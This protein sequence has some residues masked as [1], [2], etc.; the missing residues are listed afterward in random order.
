MN[1]FVEVSESFEY[2]DM[3]Y[4]AV[5]R[6]LFLTHVEGRG[7]LLGGTFCLCRFVAS[8][9]LGTASCG[10]SNDAGC[11]R[12]DAST[13]MAVSRPPERR[14]AIR[15]AVPSLV[16][17]VR[18]SKNGAVEFGLAVTRERDTAVLHFVLWVLATGLATAAAGSGTATTAAAAGAEAKKVGSSNAGGESGARRGGSGLGDGIGVVLSAVTGIITCSGPGEGGGPSGSSADKDGGGGRLG[19]GGEG[20]SSDA[21]GGGEA[22]SGG[23]S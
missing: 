3:L 13:S 21:S 23:G 11:S 1:R 2:P 10:G 22:G 17:A 5:V 18:P 15:T 20:G 7:C 6:S 16:P 8:C 9:I 19:V 12:P 14:L 4:D